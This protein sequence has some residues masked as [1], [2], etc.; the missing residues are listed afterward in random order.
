MTAV[1]TAPPEATDRLRAGASQLPP[2]G[3]CSPFSL[4]LRLG[5]TLGWSR[6]LPTCF[7]QSLSCPRRSWLPLLGGPGDVLRGWSSPNSTPPSAAP[8]SLG[9]QPS[10]QRTGCWASVPPLARPPPSAC[11]SLALPLAGSQELGRSPSRP[12]KQGVRPSLFQCGGGGPQSKSLP[13]T[14]VTRM[15]VPRSLPGLL[16]PHQ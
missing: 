5:H 10:Q 14:T 2:Q 11:R 16:T 4:K 12:G 13:G 1:T 8:A 15:G 3:P 9:L 7:H 6:S